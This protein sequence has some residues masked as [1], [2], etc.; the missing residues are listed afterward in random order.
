MKKLL[1]ILLIIPQICFAEAFTMKGGLD[2]GTWL[3]ARQ[4]NRAGVLEAHIQGFVNGWNFG[5]KG[6]DIWLKPTKMTD[7]QV[8]YYI[9][10]EC[11]KNPMDDPRVI[12]LKFLNAR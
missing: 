9:D 6:K 10:A 7:S 4:S 12:M 2:C 11:R 3:V 1:L 8:Y 5:R